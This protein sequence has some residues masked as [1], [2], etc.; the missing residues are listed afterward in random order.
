MLTV[1]SRR[2]SDGRPLVMRQAAR[3]DTAVAGPGSV[4]QPCA[5]PANQVFRA[6]LIAS[7][8]LKLRGPACQTVAGNL[9]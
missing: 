3:I 9:L 4:S 1:D 6:L 7:T 8:G 5:N 2:R